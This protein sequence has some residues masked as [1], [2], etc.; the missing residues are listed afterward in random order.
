M[1]ATEATVS[2]NI[3]ATTLTA[4]QGGSIGPWIFNNEAIY[5]GKGIG[6]AG[7]CGISNITGYSF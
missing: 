6:T 5:N 4:I 3:T 7:S 1:S 2:G